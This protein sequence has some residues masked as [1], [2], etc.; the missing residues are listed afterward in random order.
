MFV[1]K[2][3]MPERQSQNSIVLYNIYFKQTYYT[4]RDYKK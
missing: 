4:L 1:Y 3:A 2:K